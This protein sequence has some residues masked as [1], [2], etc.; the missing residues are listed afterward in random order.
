[1]NDTHA[2]TGRLEVSIPPGSRDLALS[3]EKDNSSLGEPDSGV[4]PENDW[5]G[6]FR[7]DWIGYF[8][9]TFGDQSGKLCIAVKKPSDSGKPKMEHRYFDYPGYLWMAANYINQNLQYDVYFCAQL[10]TKE[11]RVKENVD[12]CNFVWADLDACPINELL[13][14]PTTVIET[15]EGRTQGLWHLEE[16]ISGIDAEELSRRV[17]YSHPLIDNGWPLTKLLRVPWTFNYK[18]DRPQMVGV[19]EG[20][21]TYAPEDFDAFPVVI[22][23][24]HKGEPVVELPEP[25]PLSG[26]QLAWFDAGLGQEA[27]GSALNAAGEP[28][29]SLVFRT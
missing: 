22:D 25:K 7:H 5:S 8:H 1:M 18:R 24:T 4:K 6:M 28:D 15:S 27:S 23:L 26:G 21:T 20:T 17:A 19:H 16:P 2:K 14:K 13:L 12:R 3:P 11:R 29:D 9:R 10:L